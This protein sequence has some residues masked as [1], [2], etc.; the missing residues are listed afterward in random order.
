MGQSQ[1]STKPQLKRP[2][3][4]M[5]VGWHAYESYL[6]NFLDLA[7][8]GV[9]AAAREADCNLLLA[10][11]VR[12]GLTEDIQ[13]LI[14]PAWPALSPDTD[15]VPVG[16]WTTDGM[17]VV[18]PL[19]TGQRS[20]YIHG[21]RANGHPVIFLGAGESGSAVIA[22]SWACIRQAVGLLVDH[23]HRSIAYIAGTSDTSTRWGDA[24]YRLAAYR[25][26]VRE[27]GLQSNEGLLAYGQNNVEGG[28][29][30]MRQLLNSPIPFRAVIANN[31]DVAVGAIHMLQAT[32]RRVPEDVAIFG[33]DDVRQGFAVSPA[34]TAVHYP[35][36]EAAHLATNLLLA[37][38]EG[39]GTAEELV[40]VSTRLVIRQ[41][42]GC[43][44]G[45]QVN[46][47]D[48]SVGGSEQTTL[49]ARL[50]DREL[51]RQYLLSS[52]VELVRT[53]AQRLHT[54]VIY[55]LCEKLVEPLGA[56]TVEADSK[57]F[58]TNLEWVMETLTA[59]EEDVSLW[60]NAMLFLDDALPF[61]VE[62]YNGLSTSAEVE[63]MLRQARVLIGDHA[64]RQH[65]QYIVTQ[66]WIADEVGRLASRF[67]TSPDEDHIGKTLSDYLPNLGIQIADIIFFERD[68]ADPVAWANVHRVSDEANKPLRF[69]SREFPPPGLYGDESLFMLALLPLVIPTELA[70]FVAFDTSALSLC[71]PIVRQLAAA[72]KNAR[73]YRAASEG[74]RLAEDASR[75]K[76]RL[77]S[78]ISHELRTP[79]TIIVS[80]SEILLQGRKNQQGLNSPSNWDDLEQIFDNAHY[81][82]SLIRDVLDLARGEAGQL[83]LT[84]EQLALAEVL[85][86]VA[87]TGEHMAHAKGLGWHYEIPNK[88]PPVW[89][90]ITRLRQVVLNLVSN[91]I[92]FTH[93]GQVALTV[94][95]NDMTLTVS[96]ADTGLGVPIAEQ[97]LIFDE[98]HQSERTSAR[99]FGGTGLGLAICR[100]LVELHGGHIKLQSSGKE[101]A[102]SVFS[103]TLPVYDPLSGEVSPTSRVQLDSVWLLSDVAN[104]GG[105]L[106]D[107]L[108]QQGFEVTV[109]QVEEIDDT[110]SQ[111]SISTPGA[112]VVDRHLASTQGWETLKAIKSLPSTRDIPV[113]FYSMTA[114]SDSGSVLELDYLTKPIGTAEL[115]QALAQYGLPDGSTATRT[116]LVADDEPGILELNVRMIQAWSSAYEIL[117]A[118]NG[119]EALDL[120]TK[121]QPDLVLLDLMMPEVDGFGVLDAMRQSNTTRAIPVIVLTG[122]DLTEEDMA[123]LNQGVAAVLNKGLF[124][125]KETLTHIEAALAHNRRLGS[126]TQRLVRKAVAYLQ[127][128]LADAEAVARESIAGYLGVSEDHLTRCFHQE[129][130]VTLMTYLTRYRINRAKD[131]L[132]VGDVSVAEVSEA[133]GFSDVKY[134]GRGFHR[135]V[136]VSPG[137][138]R[139][140]LR[141]RSNPDAR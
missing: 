82:E 75:L 67:V 15:F 63:A 29:Q 80:L 36:F 135:E 27:Y 89:G 93:Q 114:D 56:T 103:F 68:G 123:R 48:I 9:C 54:N 132:V 84:F 18:T 40:R 49:P 129:V 42:C 137:A 139:R 10:C 95:H 122:Q 32:G 64:R 44:P 70:G 6:S 52:M 59:V 5:I 112:V 37:S 3:I 79:L 138:Y 30:A 74:R 51:L 12:Y 28:E 38:I 102:G 34:L 85:E 131:L 61:I 76:S 106:R 127:L 125:A 25:A 108:T 26:A 92:K 39:S 99:G 121:S 23:G 58:Y 87:A 126:E 91:A 133:V 117:K 90:D 22:D 50:I 105:D 96:V 110:L 41:S 13:P 100:Q 72:Y 124:S 104:S 33:F 134:F 65:N 16:H 81:L 46:Q 69:L 20:D 7:F 119:R 24:A 128:H 62:M 97:S 66:S 53:E 115:A 71:G 19:W 21:V 2:T 57:Q 47:N 101:N 116:I 113:L 17:I 88:L 118:N 111:L 107:Y 60:G 141:S 4:G 94:S 136:G 77:L 120:I 98:F 14:H 31:D 78:I 43:Q 109:L 130:G 1:R 35:I 140:T 86:G 45:F 11:G 73:L 55:S 83:E 8:R